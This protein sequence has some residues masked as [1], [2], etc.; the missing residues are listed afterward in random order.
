MEGEIP[1]AVIE[2]CDSG[3]GRNMEVMGEILE[4]KIRVL[5]HSLSGIVGDLSREHSHRSVREE[6]VRSSR[7]N[8]L[9]C[10]G[11]RERYTL[12]NDEIR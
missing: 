9:R 11:C 2:G 7:S 5:K 1:H 12:R 10:K 4:W 8:V 3:P 6:S